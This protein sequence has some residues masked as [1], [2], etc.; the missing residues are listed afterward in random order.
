[1][2]VIS[3]PAV[4]NFKNSHRSGKLG[5]CKERPGPPDLSRK[6]HEGFGASINFALTGD[7][8]HLSQQLFG[9][10]SEK[11]SDAGIL[12]CREAEAALLQGVA[13][14]ARQRS[15]NAAI[16]IEADPASGGVS[17]FYVS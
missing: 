13:E 12:Q 1:V 9:R 5:D 11:G 16:A 10:Q 2:P 14:S 4:A 3:E 17:A 8:A 7:D 6:N 15:T